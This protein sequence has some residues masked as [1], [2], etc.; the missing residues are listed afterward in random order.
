MYNFNYH[1][2][3]TTQEASDIFSS[4]EDPKYL[5]GGMTLIASM[6]QRLVAPTDLIDLRQLNE[7]NNIT[8]DSNKIIIGALTTHY[9]ISESKE[10]MNKINGFSELASGIGDPAVRKM[11]TI[12]GSLV[13]SDPAADWPAAILALKSNLISNNRIIKNEDFFTGMFETLLEEN[14]ILT[15]IEY[16]IP[17]YFKYVKF[18]N[19]A[20]KYAIVGVAIAKYQDKVRVAITGASHT[21]FLAKEIGEAL[22]T[23]F[24]EKIPLRTIPA[25]DLNNDIHAS[26]EYRQN[27]ID[28]CTKLAVSSN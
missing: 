25:N 7:L 18:P 15:S 5:A 11:G 21:P 2:P 1:N 27:L 12:G 14:E 17:E 26:S 8:L 16:E 28:V 4:S 6:K 23:N 24:H 22:T 10:I 9:Q 20:S 13:N 19:P 3:K